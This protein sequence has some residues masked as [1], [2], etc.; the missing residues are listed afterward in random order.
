MAKPPVVPTADRVEALLRER[1]TEQ[2]LAL[3]KQLAEV[4]PGAESSAVVRT[5][6]FAH[7]DFCVGRE[8]FRTTHAALTFAE[9]LPG[10]D[11]DAVGRLA[12]WCAA[13]AT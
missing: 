10:L 9:S 1:R 13:S 2:A 8:S 12:E 5:A 11:A 4:S 7:A 3:A 6:A